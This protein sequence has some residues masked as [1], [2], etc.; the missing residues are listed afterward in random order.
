MAPK[1][2]ALLS[3]R[4]RIIYLEDILNLFFAAK[5]NSMMGLAKLDKN[6]EAQKDPLGLPGL[7]TEYTLVSVNF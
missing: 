4:R 2:T 7:S 6:F 5:R 3:K 1:N